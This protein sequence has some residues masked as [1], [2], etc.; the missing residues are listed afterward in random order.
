MCSTEVGLHLALQMSAVCSC[1]SATHAF[2]VVNFRGSTPKRPPCGLP[3]AGRTVG[4]SSTLT[5]ASLWCQDSGANNH[6]S[7]PSK[8]NPTTGFHRETSLGIRG[9]VDCPTNLSFFTSQEEQAIKPLRARIC[10]FFR[11]KAPPANRL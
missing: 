10:L 1:L 6:K 8:H 4:H 11:G 5:V 2:T 3:V 7:S 9:G